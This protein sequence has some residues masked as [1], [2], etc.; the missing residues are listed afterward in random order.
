MIS[1]WFNS[2]GAI[3]A[4]ANL[5]KGILSASRPAAASKIQGQPR[6]L[7]LKKNFA[8]TFL[9]NVIYGACQ[10]GILVFLAKIGSPEMVGQFALGLAVCIPVLMFTNLN[11]RN[12]QATDVKGEFL[13]GQYLGLRLLTTG[14]AVL[15]IS[16]ITLASGY[17][18]ET[19]LVIL[20]VGVAK[21][22]ESVIDALYGLLQQHE[23]MNRI[24]SSMIIRSLLYLLGLGL[25]VYLTGNILWGMAGFAAAGALTLVFC[26]FRHGAQVINDSSPQAAPKLSLAEAMRPRWEM[27]A[28]KKLIRLSLPLGLS[29]MLMSLTHNIP[30]YFIEHYLGV[31]EL[32][33]F[34]AI[35]QL[36]VAGN[37]V[38]A[39]L[40]SSASPR[41]A[42]YFALGEHQNFR[43]L[44][45][46]LVGIGVFLGVAGFLVT[47]V[48]GYQILAIF[49]RPEYARN[50]DVFQQVMLAAGLFYIGS[51]LG[52]AVTATRAF[53]S[54][55]IPYLCG[56]LIS[57]AA[58]WLLIPAFGLIG[59]AYALNANAL[60]ICVMLLFIL[61]KAEKQSGAAGR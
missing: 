14:L 47:W 52:Y 35:T 49:Y 37:T 3:Q 38:V 46:K 41:L 7:S 53:D 54:F 11:L 40:G 15:A 57:L 27:S 43:G 8:W 25:G 32:G 13:F 58:A 12:V 1:R 20:A 18:R 42:R 55:V 16:G 36:M 2:S 51:F 17:S 31:R 44:V 39:A 29:M 48:A 22:L 33:I 24:A 21:A 26:D 34:A 9:G 6:P 4:E 23:R 28:V 50:A 59:A 5:S 19:K 61:K 10:W 60:A 30:R 56:T 45:L